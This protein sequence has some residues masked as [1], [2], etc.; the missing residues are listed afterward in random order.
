M[1]KHQPIFNIKTLKE[2]VY[3]YLRAQIRKGDL[4]PGAVIDL[5]ETSRKIGVSKTPLRDALFQLEAEGFVTIQPRRRIIVNPLTFEDIQEYYEI[6]G[7]LESTALRLAFG[8]FQPSCVK[9]MEELV[10]RMQQAFDDHDYDVY[11]EQ[12]LRFHQEILDR[13]GNTRL[14]QAVTTLKKR[15]YDFTRQKELM[16]EWENSS[17]GEHRQLVELIKQGRRDAAADFIRDVHWSYQVQEKFIGIY[18]ADIVTP[19]AAGARSGR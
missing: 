18:Y 1:E 4:R 9:H 17:I 8:R 5:D 11:Y 2:Q 6:I 16:V 15:L 3:E 14:V 7:S 12:N 10:T 19:P 13:C